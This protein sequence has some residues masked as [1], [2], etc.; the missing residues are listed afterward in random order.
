[1]GTKNKSIALVL[2]VLFLTS[3]VTVPF[4]ISAKTETTWNIQT[5]DK[6]GAFL[7][8]GI[9]RVDSN[10]KPHIAYSDYA[11]SDWYNV[12]IM[13]ASYT[14]SAWNIQT[15]AKDGYIIDF[16]LDSHDNP[17]IIYQNTAG[18]GY[19]LYYASWNGTNWVIQIVDRQGRLPA[20]LAMD[21]ADKP[22]IAYAISDLK[23]ASLNGSNWNIQDVRATGNT[24][25]AF[26]ALDKNDNPHILYEEG[27]WY[28]DEKT[29]KYAAWNSDKGWNFQ[30]VITNISSKIGNLALD[31]VGYP[32]FIYITYYR[33]LAYDSWNGAAWESQTV[34]SNISI[35]SDGYFTLDRYDQPHIVYNIDS[36]NF[37]SL[38]GGDLLYARWAG[39]KWD[40]QTVVNNTASGSGTVVLDS[41]DSIHI[42]YAGHVHA[43]N[44]SPTDIMYAT[45]TE[46]LLTPTANPTATP[47]PF[48]ANGA[49][50]SPLVI[51]VIAVA[52]TLV[53]GIASLLLY[54][55]HRKIISQNNPNV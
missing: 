37:H 8:G 21:S 30:T 48:S 20:S 4:A 47:T 54:R 45:A 29:I 22:H 52:A 39:N 24:S 11:D 31:S 23:Y 26:L 41:N 55:R 19:G 36:I 40:I 28:Q 12:N 50:I 3:L 32:H 18:N 46:P 16:S 35:D 15:V 1:M 34:D 5:V 27:L 13:Y 49:L 51:A 25:H 53:V 42:S 2:V 9:I 38:F 43:A 33:I 6:Y 7:Q 10:N 14:G 17:H 44:Q